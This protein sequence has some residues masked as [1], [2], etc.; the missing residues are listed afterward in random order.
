MCCAARFA[1]LLGRPGPRTGPRPVPASPSHAG[2]RR[3]LGCRS[4]VALLPPS[5]PGPG[6]GL[7]RRS[8]VLGVPPVRVLA[9]GTASAARR[10]AACVAA[11]PPS[12]RVRPAV[13]AAPSSCRAGPGSARH[14][15]AAALL[16]TP[17][18]LS[19]GAGW[20]CRS[21]WH[22]GRA[23][24]S[25]PFG[26]REGRTALKGPLRSRPARAAPLTAV[27]LPD[28]PRGWLAKPRPCPNATN[29]GQKHA[30]WPLKRSDFEHPTSESA[31]VYW[32][33][34]RGAAPRRLFRRTPEPVRR[35]AHRARWKRAFAPGQGRSAAT[36]AGQGVV[37]FALTQVYITRSRRWVCKCAWRPAMSRVGT[38]AFAHR[39]PSVC[40]RL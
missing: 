39:V 12:R 30:F 18:A 24:A 5:R 10:A 8:A 26:V 37:V 22:R 14:H 15:T 31:R 27:R 11:L 32:R 13:P 34:R 29:P 6:F 2:W 40:K 21:C 19:P 16:A 9:L 33:F 35:H 3:L 20:P 17:R 28:C 23:P 38:V 25:Q 4:P 1:A 36:T 7:G